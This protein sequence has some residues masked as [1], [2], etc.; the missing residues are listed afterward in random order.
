MENKI[1]VDTYAGKPV[2]GKTATYE[3]MID[4]NKDMPNFCG[5]W[6]QFDTIEEAEEWINNNK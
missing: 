4:I 5:G 1:Y 3:E 2:S 6:K